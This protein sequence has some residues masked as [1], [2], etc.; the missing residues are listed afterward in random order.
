MVEQATDISGLLNGRELPDPPKSERRQHEPTYPLNRSDQ[1]NPLVLLLSGLGGHVFPF[2]KVAKLVSDDL[3]MTGLLYPHLT[4]NFA[5]FSKVTQLAD[6]FRKLVT[7][8]PDREIF[9]FGYSFGG[10]VAFELSKRLQADGY[11]VGLILFDTS[12]RA[13][14]KK[15]Q[16]I[17][18]ILRDV[19]TRALELAQYVRANVRQDH[20]ERSKFASIGAMRH[21]KPK[22]SSV[23]TVLIK[24]KVLPRFSKYVETEDLG[25]RAVT[26]VITV[27][28]TDGDHLDAFKGVNAP[29]FARTLVRATHLIRRSHLETPE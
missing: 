26:N 11:T 5:H 29:S 3:R 7:A 17:K 9:I 28:E 19:R 13:L 23:S 1:K 4:G 25:W 6:H 8:P 21:Y 24:P 16:P 2:K 18:F 15:R 22:I 10:A 27:L 20:P 14:Q 12:L